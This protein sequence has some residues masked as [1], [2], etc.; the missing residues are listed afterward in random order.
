MAGSSEAWGLSSPLGWT[1]TDPEFL[2][3]ETPEQRMALLY[4]TL[5]CFLRRPKRWWTS[6]G[7]SLAEPQRL[8]HRNHKETLDYSPLQAGTQTAVSNES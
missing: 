4:T 3:C 8:C 5:V 2:G 6:L 7:L 1:E